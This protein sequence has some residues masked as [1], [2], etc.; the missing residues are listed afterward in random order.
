MDRTSIGVPN[1]QLQFFHWLAN[2]SFTRKIGRRI[3][4]VFGH[5]HERV[6]SWQP[7]QSA[8]MVDVAPQSHTNH[9]YIDNT[10]ISLDRLASVQG[11][12]RINHIK[13]G[14]W[15]RGVVQLQ[16]RGTT[17]R[18]Q[19]RKCRWGL[20]LKA[21]EGTLFRDVYH[22]PYPVRH[23]VV[24]R[25]ILRNDLINRVEMSVRPSFQAINQSLYCYIYI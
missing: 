24:F 20:R 2:H 10:P 22:T 18:N 6:F 16:T 17:N 9:V 7:G 19:C 11:G 15:R 14:M 5:R 23:D 21:S 8:I 3:W 25:S 1:S 4:T 12:A 13:R